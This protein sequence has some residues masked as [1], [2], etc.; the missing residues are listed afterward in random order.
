M[1]LHKIGIDEIVAKRD[2]DF[3]LSQFLLWNEERGINLYPAQEE[4]VMEI[5]SDRHVI[6]T[7]P[8]GSGKSLIAL[9]A[10]LAAM[11][12]GV[13]SAYTAPI[14]A[15]VSE[16]FFDLCD[17]FGPENVGMMTSDA[18]I[19]TG[20]PIICATAEI[21][22]NIALREGS[23]A[24]F[25][26]VVMDEFHFYGDPDRGWAW[27]V[28]LLEM[29]KTQFILMS[30]TLGDTSNIE[31]GLKNRTDRDVVVVKS[32]L[33]PIPLVF[34]Y[35]RKLLH[36]TIG[37]LLVNDRAPIYIVH[38][39]QASAARQAQSLT[40]LPVV[41]KRQR[42]AIVKEIGD[43]RF[44]KGYGVTLSRLLHH[45]IGV[46]HGGM[47]PKY[48]RLVE[49]LAQNGLLKLIVGTDTLGV[50]I[51]MPIRTVLLTSL[52]KYD[53]ISMRLLSA[54]E[55]HQIAGRAGRAG[56]D[57]VGYVVLQAPEHLVSNEIAFKKAEKKAEERGRKKVKVSM[58]KPPKGFIYFD[59]STFAKLIDSQPEVLISR[60]KV[61]HAVVLNILD[62]PGDNCQALRRLLTQNDEP[63]A[64]QRK[65][66]K[67]AISIYRSLLQVKA[68][69]R[70]KTKD[71][72]G[73]L[74]RVSLDLQW[75]FALNNPLSPFVLDAIPLLDSSLDT[76]D[77][78]VISVIESTLEN[79][80][81]IL[82]AQLDKIR[83]SLMQELKSTGVEYEDR[84]EAL[85]KAEY[86]KPLRDFIY[87]L[88]DEYRLIH[89]WARDNNISPK[90]IVRDMYEM[91]MSFNEY[92]A[93]YGIT[94]SEGL[95]LRYLSD[96]YKALQQNIPEDWKSD[97]LQD[98]ILWLGELVRQVDSSLIDE[99]EMLQ[100][101]DEVLVLHGKESGQGNTVGA[102]W[103][104]DDTKK[105]LLT[106]RKRA[107]TIMV[108]N[109]SFRRV[110]LFAK[111]DSESLGESEDA[112]GFGR[113]QWQEAIESYFSMYQSVDISQNARNINLCQITER[114][115]VW[116]IS[117]SILDPENNC[118]FRVEA[119]IDLEGSNELGYPA[120][121]TLSVS[122]AD[123]L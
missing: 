78:D 89:P 97:T 80:G 112:P 95:L 77:L 92:V 75:D 57:Q 5:F 59:E 46:H 53:G 28:P 94:R 96:A 123:I 25:G 72:F 86:P 61:D 1:N 34:D 105:L 90:S 29:Q 51:N 32:A 12:S 79:P 73:R 85:D 20:A 64:N 45:G 91:S 3:A 55:F 121:R 71:E 42:E 21:V 82:T 15:L 70:L 49:R 36:D 106:E 114:Q 58:A 99:W 76:Y 38:F 44:S 14:K 24:P 27:Q 16:K 93:H 41:D 54:R 50:G 48:R 62:R 115:G 17:V 13:R 122:Q 110:E 100:H 4:A 31:S 74:V 109:A 35:S 104:N 11:A 69:E 39:T 83:S 102:L 6:V 68:L 30:A 111:K 19:N 18:S 52:N 81:A 98:I 118:D 120:W 63:R 40:S 119:A 37:D 56:F 117:Q 101:I 66:I 84:I 103:G 9:G 2:R 43:F 60:L 87:D 8:T 107:F 33:R 26:Q 113:H 22:A 65:L 10:H 23:G 67:K 88:F 7:T 108:R 116:H 47:L